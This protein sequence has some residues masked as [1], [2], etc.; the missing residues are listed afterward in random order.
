MKQYFKNHLLEF[1][2]EEVKKFLELYP[3]K[4]FY[5]FAYDCNA[6]Y[7]EVNLCFNTEEDFLETLESYQKGEYSEHYKS[8]ESIMEL[9]Y[10]TGD[11]NYQCFATLEVMTGDEL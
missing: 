9:K 7:A 5:A 4:V 8:E 1:T 11:W 3:H 6:E 2:K 10:N